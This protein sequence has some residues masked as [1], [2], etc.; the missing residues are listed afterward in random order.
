M[1]LGDLSQR[2]AISGKDE[3]G[4]LAHAFNAMA[5]SLSQAERLRRN[6]VSDLAHELRGPLMNIRG[7]LELLQDQI[8]EP[9]PAILAS[10]Y[11]ETSLLSRL[12]DDLQDLSLAEAGQ[13]RLCRQQTLLAEVIAQATL[14]LQPAFVEKHLS[15]RIDIPV[16]LPA[17]DADPE[18]LAQIVRN[19]LSNAIRHTPSGGEISVSAR[20]RAGAMVAVGVADTG[21]GI[22]GEHLPHIFERFYRIDSSRTRASGGTGLGLAIVKQLVEAHQGRIEVESEQGHGARFTFTMPTADV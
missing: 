19:L 17:V 21:E 8:L 16:G 3:I 2:V 7:S 6:L 10:L 5:D 13:L 20:L 15:L 4:A 12:V 22:A 9:S 1:E 18:R 14:Q 11:E